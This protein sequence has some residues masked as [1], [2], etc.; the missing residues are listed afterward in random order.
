[1]FSRGLPLLVNPQKAFQ[2]KSSL[3][4]AKAGNS[5]VSM[6][7][8]LISVTNRGCQGIQST[9]TDLGPQME[10]LQVVLAP[11]I[12]YYLNPS[13]LSIRKQGREIGYVNNTVINIE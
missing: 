11:Y 9:T 10:L 5:L 1:M 12:K 7:V 8:D 2:S 4:K 3:G 13:L 6:Y